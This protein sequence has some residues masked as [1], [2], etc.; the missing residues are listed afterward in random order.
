MAKLIIANAPQQVITTIIDNGDITVLSRYNLTSD[1]FGPYKEHIERI[2]AYYNQYGHTPGESTIESWWE[3]NI[4]TETVEPEEEITR[5]LQIDYFYT[6]SFNKMLNRTIDN[7]QIDPEQAMKEMAEFCRENQ[8]LIYGKVKSHRYQGDAQEEIDTLR[9]MVSRKDVIIPTGFDAIDAAIGGLRTIKELCVVF[10]RMNQGKSWVA[11]KMAV[12]SLKR[13]KKVLY[14]SGETPVEHV[15]YRLDTLLFGYPNNKLMLYDLNESDL[16]DYVSLRTS[17]QTKYSGEIEIVTP[18]D[19]LNNRKLT[20]GELRSILQ[21]ENYDLVIV[22]QLSEMDE[23]GKPSQNTKIKYKNITDR[24]AHL[25]SEFKT[26]IVLMCQASRLAGD[27][28]TEENENECPELK[29]IADSDDIPR[30]C[31]TAISICQPKP[32]ELKLAVKKARFVGKDTTARYLWTIN[33]GDFEEISS[34]NTG[35]SNINI[36]P[37][38]PQR[39]RQTEDVF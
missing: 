19:H 32:G 11:C 7:V 38:R 34:S 25:S 16:T 13:G 24:L 9:D 8:E 39:T 5:Q 4:L 17:N 2:Q 15:N 29:D 28:G 27:V 26:P 37:K 18:E 12:E 22:D 3:E 10:A 1:M 33:T 20:V 35:G 30:V 21:R 36:K 23:D 6:H 14:Y 31:T